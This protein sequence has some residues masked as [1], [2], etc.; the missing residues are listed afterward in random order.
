MEKREFIYVDCVFALDAKYEFRLLLLGQ[1]DKNHGDN[2]ISD[3]MGY[4]MEFNK[5][6]EAIEEGIYSGTLTF[7]HQ[8]HDYGPNGSEWDLDINLTDVKQLEIKWTS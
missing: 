1:C 2:V 5:P 3:W 7:V 8:K 6:D 4:E